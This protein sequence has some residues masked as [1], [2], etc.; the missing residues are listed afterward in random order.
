M[1]INGKILN[2]RELSHWKIWIRLLHN[3]IKNININKI[4]NPCKRNGSGLWKWNFLKWKKINRR[5]VDLNKSFYAYIDEYCLGILW[6]NEEFIVILL[7]VHATML[8]PVGDARTSRCRPIFSCLLVV[9]L[10][11]ISRFVFVR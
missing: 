7:S 8:H 11:F 6:G 4:K 2:Y 10:S 3:R 1:V 5:N 9:L